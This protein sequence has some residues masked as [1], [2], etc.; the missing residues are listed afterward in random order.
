[1]NLVNIRCGRCKRLLVSLTRASR[2]TVGAD[3]SEA[4]TLARCKCDLRSPHTAPSN[5]ARV[6]SLPWSEALALM[7]RAEKFGKTQTV[8]FHVQDRPA[9]NLDVPST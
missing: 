2:P 1:M 5:W 9:G 7:E 8:S 6:V 3:G 4:V